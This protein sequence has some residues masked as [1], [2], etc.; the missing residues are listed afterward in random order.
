MDTHDEQPSLFQF[1]YT[2]Q[3]EVRRG[4]R[5]FRPFLWPVIWDVWEDLRERRGRDKCFTDLTE[6]QMGI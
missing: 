4:I 3:E 1:P 6:E 5:P 2:S